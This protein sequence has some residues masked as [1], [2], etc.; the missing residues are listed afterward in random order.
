[1]HNYEVMDSFN[2]DQAIHIKDHW[3]KLFF[4]FEFDLKNTHE[5]GQNIHH[6]LI[7]LTLKQAF[8]SLPLPVSCHK[9]R[10]QSDKVWEIK[11][12]TIKPEAFLPTALKIFNQGKGCFQTLTLSQN[13]LLC[14]NDIK[15][16]KKNKRADPLLIQLGDN[17]KKR[18]G[19]SVDKLFFRIEAVHLIMLDIGVGLI[20]IEVKFHNMINPA[21][22]QEGL[23]AICRNEPPK[24]GNKIRWQD[25]DEESYILS[26]GAIIEK[27]APIFQSELAIRSPGMWRKN[28]SYTAVR[29]KN[30]SPC[31]KK[32]QELGHR[33]AKQYT[34]VYLPKDSSRSLSSYNP[35]NDISHLCSLEGGSLIH[36]ENENNTDFIKDSGKNTY[37]PICLIAFFEYLSLITLSNHESK[38]IN[39]SAPK[40]ED[41][42]H[43]NH[44]RKTMYNFR[45]NYRFSHIS[46]ISMH[47]DVHLH[48]RHMFKISEL[49][50]ELS[51]D[52]TEIENFLNTD[53]EL[54]K[55][56]S[57]KTVELLVFLVGGLMSISEFFDIKLYEYLVVDHEPLWEVNSA[58]LLLSGVTVILLI[59]NRKI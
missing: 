39:L 45:L 49:L 21:Y 13:A 50:E 10:E 32:V 56:R 2:A 20:C 46:H 15:D 30:N 12:I 40:K 28:F 22:L 24:N 35:F 51:C 8:E 17:A 43:L 16:T 41:F 26:L 14:C 47:N 7:N 54:Q 33:L 57:L 23:Y 36:I 58:L 31:P 1:M 55:Q 38:D 11:N 29:L 25:G 44:I 6:C 4:P 19:N 18:L 37:F 59:S 48:W 34:D 53:R 3:V 5:T 52:I 27:I 42:K 9:L